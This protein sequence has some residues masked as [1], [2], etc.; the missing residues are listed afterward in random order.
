ML[1]LTTVSS[2]FAT[3]QLLS[4]IP[5]CFVT[6]KRNWICKRVS[7]LK[8]KT[9]WFSRCMPE[10]SW[11]AILHYGHSDSSGSLYWTRQ[12]M[13]ISFTRSISRWFVHILLEV[14]MS[15]SFES[16]LLNRLNR[17]CEKKYV[18]HESNLLRSGSRINWVDL[19]N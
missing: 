6:V 11:K 5:S 17:F 4:V 15:C 9:P 19:R 12:N 7:S 13:Q 3:M 18:V 16:D 2:F 8:R 14:I 10:S 1:E